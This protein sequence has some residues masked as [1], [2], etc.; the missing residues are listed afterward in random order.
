MSDPCFVLFRSGFND[1]EVE[2]VARFLACLEASQ[3]G[4][5][6]LEDERLWTMDKE[7]GF[8]VKSFYLALTQG[9]DIVLPALDLF[10]IIASH[11]KSPSSFGCCGG[12]VFPPSTALLQGAFLC[13]IGAI[14]A[15]LR[16]SL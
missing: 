7:K 12:I 13:R 6:D 8:L 9:D 5:R 11:L 16:A 1:W 15:A 14:C 4:D 10:G 3:L 2:D